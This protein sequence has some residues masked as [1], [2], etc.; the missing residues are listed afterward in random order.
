MSAESAALVHSWSVGQYTATLTVPKAK[1]GVP[2]M[3]VIEWDP[4]MPERLSPDE[5]KQYRAGRNAAL[6]ALGLG[7]Q[8]IKT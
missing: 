5:I 3:A 4:E 6:A 7:A 8:A 1:P 2:V